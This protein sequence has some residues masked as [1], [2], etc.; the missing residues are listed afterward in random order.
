[1]QKESYTE[2]ELIK[3]L[4]QQENAAYQYLY[5][6]YK[7]ALYTNILQVVG[8]EESASDVLQEVIVHIWK[9]IEK[10]DETKGRLFTWMIKV[11][12]N[13]AINHTRIKNFKVHSKNQDIDNYVSIIE[14]RTA[15]FP[16]I[17]NIGLRQQVHK[18]RPELK[19]VVELFYFHGLKQDEVAEALS[20]PLGTVKTRIRNAVIELRQ[21]F[22]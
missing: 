3:A 1:M 17:N 20:I 5:N 16:A 9:N 7:G 12:R 14:E 19:D 4:K 21:H 10:Y 2:Q 15:Q 13:M 18:L 8:N 11:T 22:V 6:N